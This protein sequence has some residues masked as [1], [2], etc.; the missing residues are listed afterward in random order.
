M[1]WAVNQPKN[2]Y[3]YRGKNFTNEDSILLI[4]N[5]FFTTTLLLYIEWN[6]MFTK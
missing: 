5:K 2:Y 3:L 1:F 4:N 6:C